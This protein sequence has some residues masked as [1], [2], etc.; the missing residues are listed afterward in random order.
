VCA[1]ASFPGYGV[2]AWMNHASWVQ[3]TGLNTSVLAASDLDLSGKDDVL[4]NFAGY[5]V[6][7]YRNNAGYEQLHP[8][9]AEAVAP[10][11][12]V[13]PSGLTRD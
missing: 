5:G 6:W 8:L 13:G 10:S 7:V 9:D 3:L 4:M 11:R 2:Y 1:D 12:P